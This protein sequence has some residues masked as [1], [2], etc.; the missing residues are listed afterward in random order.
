MK[1]FNYYLMF[2]SLFLS[3]FLLP[4]QKV[5]AANLITVMV[6][7]T[8]ANGIQ[9][10]VEKDLRNMQA[11]VQ[12]IA[13]YTGLDLKTVMITGEK[14]NQARVREEINDLQVNADDVILFFY[15]G[16]GSHENKDLSNPWPY[17]LLSRDHS[18]IDLETI[19]AMLMAKHP[20]LLLSIANACNNIA[21]PEDSPGEF[22][23]KGDVD[24]S[25]LLNHD[26]KAENNYRKLFLESKG[27]IIVTSSK[28]GEVSFGR[29]SYGGYF[30]YA[31]VVSLQKAVQYDNQ[32]TW[33]SVLRNASDIVSAKQHPDYLLLNVT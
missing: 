21:P 30:P 3:I 8:M 14:V 1:F 2:L 20:H 26:L 27:A 17:L 16:H 10:G 7:D 24:Y 11:Q 22:T 4:T 25:W 9:E 6:G 32:P 29:P 19:N 15:S 31:L 23:M 33:K 12:E 18:T 5:E 28:V 13:H